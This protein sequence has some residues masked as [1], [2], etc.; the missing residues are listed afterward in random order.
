MK[1]NGHN[2]RER[3]LVAPPLGIRAP[4]MPRCEVCGDITAKYREAAKSHCSKHIEHLPYV[5]RLM[6][7][8]EAMDTFDRPGK[9]LSSLPTYDEWVLDGRPVDPS[10]AAKCG[11]E[12]VEYDPPYRETPKEVANP[13]S[14]RREA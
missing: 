12:D 14:K 7:E 2:I 10:W 5:A 6:A 11:P 13:R 3:A 9:P 1:R 8:F 4:G